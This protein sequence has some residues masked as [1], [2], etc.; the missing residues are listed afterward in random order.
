LEKNGVGPIWMIG[1][2]M[3]GFGFLFSRES[4]GYALDY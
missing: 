1:A 2:V 3:A 4:A